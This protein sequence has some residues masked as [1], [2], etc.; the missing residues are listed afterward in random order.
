MQLVKGIGV[1][2]GVL[3]SVH[4]FR[5]LQPAL[6]QKV[7]QLAQAAKERWGMPLVEIHDSACQEKGGVLAT[8]DPRTVVIVRSQLGD[9]ERWPVERLP[10][11]GRVV[12]VG[13]TFGDCHA[14]AC[15][16]LIKIGVPEIHIPLDSVLGWPERSAIQRRYLTALVFSGGTAIDHLQGVFHRLED[17][18]GRVERTDELR[19]PVESKPVVVF[20]PDQEQMWNCWATQQ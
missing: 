13:Q 5:G 7:G 18:S 4:T 16:S 14:E 8:E 20:H 17:I 2:H 10:L 3:V 15:S 19:W 9:F 12:L 11:P 6:E 1:N